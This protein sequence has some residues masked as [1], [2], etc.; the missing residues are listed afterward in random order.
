MKRLALGFVFSI[1]MLVAATMPA[2]AGGFAC[3]DDPALPLG[4]PVHS[5]VHAGLSLLGLGTVVNASTTSS[6]TSFGAGLSLP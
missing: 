2:S 3:Y 1:G 4:L 6:T 5:T